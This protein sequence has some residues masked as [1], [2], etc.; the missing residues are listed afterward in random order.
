MV[1]KKCK[2]ETVELGGKK[3]KIRKGAL[4]KQLK[5]KPNQ[6]FTI[7]QLSRL[8]KVPVGNSFKFKGN[9]FKM[10]T[11]MKQRVTLGK[12]LMRKYKK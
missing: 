6:N 10:T 7:A 5:L 4:R 1:C 8:E 9:Q 2:K 3:I 11:L 12:T